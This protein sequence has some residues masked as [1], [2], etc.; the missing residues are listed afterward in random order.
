MTL[1]KLSKANAL[2][3][4]VAL[5]MGIS[6]SST[7]QCA[8]ELVLSNS[9]GPGNGWYGNS[10]D[11]QIGANV[12]NYT[13]R[14]AKDTTIYLTVSTGD[15]IT[16][17]F[18]DT[19]Q[20]PSIMSYELFDAS[21]ISLFSSG[22]N[23]V[24]GVNFDTVANCPPCPSPYSAALNSSDTAQLSISWATTG[25][26]SYHLEW[27]VQGFNPG[28]GTTSTVTG[29]NHT[30]TGLF[31]NTCYDVY[32]QG[33]CNTSGNGMSTTAGPFTFCTKQRIIGSF[34]FVANFNSGKD[35]FGASGRFSSWELG[36]PK[37]SVIT[38]SGN[39]D[40]AWVTNLKGNHNT[41]ELSYLTSPRFDMSQLTGD[42]LIKFSLNIDTEIDYDPDVAYLEVTYDGLNWHRVTDNGKTYNWYNNVGSQTWEGTLN[43]GWKY[44]SII[45][46]T[47]DGKSDV[48]FRFVFQSGVNHQLEGVGV[49][50]FAVMPLTCSIPSNVSVTSPSATT[51]TIVW[52][53][54]ATHSNVEYGTPGFDVGSGTYIFNMSSGD[55]ISGL[56]P[57][58]MYEFYIQDSCG[59]GS[60][61]LWIGPFR[62]TTRQ[63]TVSSFPYSE[64]FEADA[65]GWISGG[66]RSSWECG[67]PSGA[68]ISGTP[69]GA[70]AWVT[71][72]DSA[73]MND[74][75]SYLQSLIFDCSG[76]AND[77]NYS[78]A[79]SY[80]TEP[81]QDFV[82]VEYSFDGVNWT[83]LLNQ[84]LANN[85]YNQ[86]SN[87]TWD[88]SSGWTM[89][90]NIITGS[91]GKSYVQI[92]HRLFSDAGWQLDGVGIDSVYAD[93]LLCSVSSAI[94][95][96]AL[97]DSSVVIKWNSSGSHFNVEWGPQGFATGTGTGPLNTAHTTNTS[98]SI[99]GLLPNTSYDVY[100]QDSCAQGNSG[101][102]GPYT[103][104]TLCSGFVGDHY[105]DP[106]VATG[107]F[108]FTGNI[109]TCYS[110][111]VS[112]R[113]SVEAVFEY[114]PSSGTTMAT[115]SACGTVYD[116]Y[117]YLI[118]SDQTTVLTSN[119]DGCGYQSLIT[120]YP[121]APG[122]VYYVVLEAYDQTDAVGSFQFDITEIN[123]CPTPS[124]L[125]LID[126]TCSSATLAWESTNAAAYTI[127]YGPAGF[128]LGNGTIVPTIDTSIVLNS[129][130]GGTTYD[131]YVKGYCPPGA[132]SGLAGPLTITVPG[133]KAVGSLDS[134]NTGAQNAIAY[135]NAL[136]SSGDSI[137]WNFG[138]G[139]GTFT[140]NVISHT[141]IQSGTYDVILTAH[142]DCG[143][144]SIIITVHVQLISIPELNPAHFHV[145]PN[146]TSGWI[147]IELASAEG[148]IGQLQLHD[149]QG[150]LI[151]KIQ[152]DSQLSN[153]KIDLSHLP[154]GLYVIRH[155]SQ[156]NS[157]NRRV[158]LR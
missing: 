126:S 81:N 18:I 153:V 63:N 114:T 1:S 106:I 93:E 92:R 155:I 41:T 20:V 76:M 122:Q 83:K 111:A 15:S 139:T 10:I 133:S 61:G 94:R 89:R 95:D 104:R 31:P 131:V 96:S 130:N 69:H 158:I 22:L 44:T 107:N 136:G 65:G 60:S 86:S 48:A 47:I 156:S 38:P 3:L 87:Q 7:A 25:A 45:M 9:A 17:S 70:K 116:T 109:S 98:L 91:A 27:G 68:F 74:E 2:F 73:Y 66:A 5:I 132:F 34:P 75:S 129:L 143:T 78:F 23:P 113:P 26:A 115:F 28:T 144:D 124:G 140:G 99:T 16:L 149:A 105:S 46:D 142:S 85:W 8:Y 53:S 80:S 82:W 110:N 30:I 40:Q 52:T 39:M 64:S 77:L 57:G 62:F 67:V 71:D 157:A 50:D 4:L 42:I 58:A 103:F 135:F 112:L 141:Y 118:A 108:S 101:W 145:Y 43:S 56:L 37:G 33:D 90:S 146:P 6:N 55:S 154:K 102:R 24:A 119:D 72:L 32:I 49:D 120:G 36:I 35:E 137:T 13:S 29:T 100:I 134:L 127:E 152:L 123:A 117:L 59:I 12:T 14:Y 97:T 138:D 51:A 19:G 11:V 150:R 151:E 79:M 54:V 88:G 21:A 128:S 148:G 121:V 84:G 125:T 147:T